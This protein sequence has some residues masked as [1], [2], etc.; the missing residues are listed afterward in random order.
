MHVEL[1]KTI[2]ILNKCDRNR[3]KIIWFL[4]FTMH[5]I[6][7]IADQK[8]REFVSDKQG[9]ISYE[10]RARDYLVNANG[11]H[12]TKVWNG[13]VPFIWYFAYINAFYFLMKYHYHPW[14]KIVL[15]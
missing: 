9:K 3:K 7:C 4:I 1:E 8:Q 2:A 5:K 12:I 14:L 13:I 15:E 10:K 6:G 11:S